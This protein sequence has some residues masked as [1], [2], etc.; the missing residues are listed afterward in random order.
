M[1]AGFGVGRFE[2]GDLLQRV[3][4]GCRTRLRFCLLAAG[5]GGQEQQAHR[6][7]QGSTDN[8][9]HGA[10][11]L[12][13]QVRTTTFPPRHFTSSTG[14]AP[15]AGKILGKTFL[16]G[17]NVHVLDNTRHLYRK[18]GKPP[19]TGITLVYLKR[20]YMIVSFGSASSRH[21]SASERTERLFRKRSWSGGDAEKT[22]RSRLYRRS[23]D[24]CAFHPGPHR[25]HRLLVRVKG[26]VE[27]G[28]SSDDHGLWRAD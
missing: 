5:G 26:V 10:P 12:I 6:D 18:S 25:S 11:C 13:D 8:V 9:P 17:L 2:I 3:L 19:V 4:S 22:R 23:I 28:F 7:G 20:M 24:F 15:D 14:S 27:S 16:P 21:Q 1:V